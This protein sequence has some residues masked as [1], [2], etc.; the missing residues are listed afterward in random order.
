M[1][2]FF[3]AEDDIRDLTV[4]GVQTCALPISRARGTAPFPTATLV[5]PVPGRG[6]ARGGPDT[7][8]RREIGREA[9]RE[10]VENAV[11]RLAPKKTQLQ[12]REQRTRANVPAHPQIALGQR[13][14][15]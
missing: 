8:P 9:C 10:R 3:Q 2:I 1:S 4:T 13:S 15:A 6:S 7:A 14:T 11:A 5:R 12:C